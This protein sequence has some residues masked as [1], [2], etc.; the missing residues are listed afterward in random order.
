MGRW[1]GLARLAWRVEMCACVCWGCA[2]LQP[3]PPRARAQVVADHLGLGHKSGLPYVSR[4]KA[5][6]TTV[7]DTKA[8][9]EV[10][11][12]GSRGCGDAEG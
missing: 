4:A 12:V 10:W 9:L 7:G 1:L 3:A 8:Q 11:K 5:P 6:A 2:K